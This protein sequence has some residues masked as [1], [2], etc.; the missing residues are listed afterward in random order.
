MSKLSHEPAEFTTL[1]ND[2]IHKITNIAAL[3]LYCY[4]R[5]LNAPIHTDDV[6]AHFDID[7]IKLTECLNHL[8]NL[9]LMQTI[10][11]SGMYCD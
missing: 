8:G 6:L 3:G 4:I 10:G 11:I 9:G 7:K 2:A 1:E 5:S